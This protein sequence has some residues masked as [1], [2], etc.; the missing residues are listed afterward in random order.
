M[1][2]VAIL[3]STGSI[4]TQALQVIQANAEAFRVVALTCHSD[5]AKLAA[6][7]LLFHP[8]VVGISDASQYQ[9]AKACLGNTCEIVCGEDAHAIALEA[10]GADTSLISIVGFA[11]LK[12]LLKSIELG[13]HTCVANKESI[14]CGGSVV[15]QKLLEKKM[16]L[17]PVDSEHSAIF[18]CLEGNT[19]RAVKRLLLTCSGG[20]FR[21]W[22]RSAIAAATSQQAG[23]H[24]TWNMGKKITIDSATLANKG[25]EVM[26]AR[27]LFDMPAEKIDVL[28]HPQSIIHSMVEFCDC[29]VLAQLGQP[30]MRLPIQF[31][32]G[33]PVRSSGEVPALDFLTC[34]ALTFEKPDTNRFPALALAYRAC[35]E[36]GLSPLAYNAANDHA[37]SLYL[38]DKVQF[39]RMATVIE[40]TLN[41]FGGG[42]EPD[43]A[44][45]F[46]AD[47]TIRA[48]LAREYC[49]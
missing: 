23:N 49:V 38:K 20:P 37:V 14:V 25:L 40:K 22:E 46:E 7:V 6:Q 42:Q 33:Y 3:G 13:L 21:T 47:R 45:I 5:I 17:Y 1:R 11:G 29:S 16:R 48:W 44:T 18:Q 36:G 12:P 15:K 34:G 30:D 24:P 9:E 32:L 27:W 39:Y 28:V 2:N 19:G 8:R 4:G 10:S 41:R 43:V 26:E 35:R 31:A